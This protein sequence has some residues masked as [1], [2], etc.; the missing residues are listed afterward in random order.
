[1]PLE[2]LFR[3]LSQSTPGNVSVLEICLRLGIASIVG[4]Y[5]TY[6][7]YITSSTDG[8]QQKISQA[9]VLL[10][11]VCALII[12]VIGHNIAWAI[13][14]IGTLSFVRFRTTLRD[15]R[16]T[17]I[18]FYSIALGISCGAGEYFLSLVGM[19]IFTAVVFI[20]PWIPFFT[21]EG[22]VLRVNGSTKEENEFFEE[23]LKAQKLHYKFIDI[24]PKKKNLKYKVFISRKEL[25]PIL[26]KLQMDLGDKFVELDKE[27]EEI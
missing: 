20:F 5:I 4:F 12:N 21:R 26:E 9:Q 23:Y 17:A 27:A 6:I 24:S 15:P 25:L 13:G 10:T 14:L 18:F 11:V 8:N 22:Y 3:Q 16:D 19:G 7:S 2:E 1:M